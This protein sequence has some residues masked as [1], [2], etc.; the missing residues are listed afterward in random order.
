[1]PEFRI[2]REARELYRNFAND[3][4]TLAAKA[5]GRRS[6]AAKE[7]KEEIVLFVGNLRLCSRKYKI[8]ISLELELLKYHIPT[9]LSP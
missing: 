5:R 3:G 7:K 8:P 4:L 9:Y 1:V 2:C 6:E